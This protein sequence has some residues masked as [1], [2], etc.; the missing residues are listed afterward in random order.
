MATPNLHLT[1]F[2]SAG[3]SLDYWQRRGMFSRE[4]ALYRRLT[5]RG[6]HVRFITYGNASEYAMPH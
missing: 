5:E 1:L 3:L 4:V 2:F 6:V